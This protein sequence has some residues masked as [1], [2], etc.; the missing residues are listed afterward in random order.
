MTEVTTTCARSEELTPDQK[1]ALR[2]AMLSVYYRSIGSQLESRGAPVMVVPPEVRPLELEEAL[3]RIV[4]QFPTRVWDAYWRIVRAVPV[5]GWEERPAVRRYPRALVDSMGLAEVEDLDDR[6]RR[7]RAAAQP[8]AAAVAACAE[9]RWAEAEEFADQLTRQARREGS[10]AQKFTQ[11]AETSLGR[12]GDGFLRWLVSSKRK[13]RTLDELRKL[14]AEVGINLYEFVEEFA[15]AVAFADFRD[16]RGAP[17][18]T[19]VSSCVVRQDTNTL[20]TTA[21]VTTLVESDFEAL[22]RALDPLGWPKYSDVIDKTEYL[23]DPADLTSGRGEMPLGAGF[24]EE[25]PRYLFE[26]V[27]IDW[28]TGGGQTGEFRNVLA[29]DYF[30]VTP[31]LQS[32]TLPFRLCRSVDSRMLWDKRAGGILSDGGKLVAR[33]VGDRRWR[34]TTRKVL[35]FSDRTPYSNAPG[36]RDFGQLLNYLAPAAVTWW[37]ETEMY[38]TESEGYA[39]GGQQSGGVLQTEGEG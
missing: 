1:A 3:R 22:A 7:S 28:G 21:T 13:K 17:K 6:R 30:S 26:Q 5:E 24:H 16:E 12:P 34:L 27:G 25:E 19:L 36:W 18:T 31:G 35:R 14:R 29:I 39:N 4:E 32:I 33:P 9:E 11:A 10:D 23:D 2:Y 15:D 37:L 20:T 8:F 38:S